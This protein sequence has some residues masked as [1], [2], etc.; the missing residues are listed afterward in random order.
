MNSE[1]SAPLVSFKSHTKGKNADVTIYSDRVEWTQM[2]ERSTKAAIATMGA[3]L[4]SKRRQGA[5]EMLPVKS[6]T[7]VTTERDGIRF[8]KVVLVAP[9]NN[10][11]FRVAHDEAKEIKQVLNRLLLGT[12]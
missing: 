1:A 9:G 12:E 10:V 2:K 3:S 7:S 6:I 11:E 8:T 4:L 5:S